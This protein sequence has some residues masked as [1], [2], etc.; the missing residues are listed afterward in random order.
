MEHPIFVGI[1]LLL[2]EIRG[3]I[4][5]SFLSLRERKDYGGRS[6]MDT[7][8]ISEVLHDEDAAVETKREEKKFKV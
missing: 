8:D 7:I 6:L 1:Y 2:E 3:F 4:G 5:S